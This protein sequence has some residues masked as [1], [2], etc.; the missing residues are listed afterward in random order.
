MK[1]LADKGAGSVY[2]TDLNLQE[3]DVYAAFGSDWQEM[4]DDVANA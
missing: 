2:E 3:E 1:S 4:V